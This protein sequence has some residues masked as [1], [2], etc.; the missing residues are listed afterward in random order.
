MLVLLFSYLGGVYGRVHEKV[1]YLLVI[2]LRVGDGH[3]EG[4]LDPGV[5]FLKHVRECSRGYAAVLSVRVGCFPPKTPIIPSKETKG[6]NKTRSWVSAIKRRH[7]FGGTK[8]KA[9]ISTNFDCSFKDPKGA[10]HLS[11]TAIL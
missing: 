3:A 11:S 1:E 9:N 4:G 2:D 8:G 7:V 5:H 10:I 6:R